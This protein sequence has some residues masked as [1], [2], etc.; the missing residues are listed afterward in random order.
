MKHNKTL[1]FAFAAALTLMASCSKE[2]LSPLRFHATIDNN[3]A[4][5]AYVGDQV[6]WNENEAIKIFS[7]GNTSGETWTAN[8]TDALNATFTHVG[9]STMEGEETTTYYA[10]SNV[11]TGNNNRLSGETL[12]VNI[13]SAVTADAPTTFMASK[14][15][16]CD[17]HFKHFSGLLQFD[18]TASNFPTK[19]N[20]KGATL[21]SI[22]IS[23]T[24]ADNYLA[25]VFGIS[26]NDEGHP[27]AVPQSGATKTLT[28]TT[29]INSGRLYFPIMPGHYDN[30][31]VTFTCKKNNKSGSFT[32]TYSNVT[33][34]AGQK[35]AIANPIQANSW[36]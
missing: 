6:V 5:C 28:Y 4:K 15:A 35:R 14:S 22:S 20:L 32:K 30:L 24:D 1:F 12:S 7:A 25:G 11:L 13:N 8:V 9:H 21:A 18:Y 34:A 36:Q 17:L 27:T 10:V 19:G 26:F 3:D 33:F 31:T 29:S 2:E 16:G 23:T